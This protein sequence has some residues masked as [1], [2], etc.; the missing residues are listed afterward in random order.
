MFMN[1]IAIPSGPRSASYRALS[2][3]IADVFK[4]V[5]SSQTDG[6][7]IRNIML[8]ASQAEMSDLPYGK[9]PTDGTILTDDLNPI[10][11]YLDQA[12]AGEIHFRRV[13][14]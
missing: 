12:N 5:R 6:D 2:A 9:A 13:L 11:I 1:L 4:D 10:E 14:E 3:T 7:T 8:A